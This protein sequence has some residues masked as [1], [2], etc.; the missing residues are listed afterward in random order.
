MDQIQVVFKRGTPERKA[1]LVMEAL[2]TRVARHR[3]LSGASMNYCFAE[4]RAL[5]DVV[6]MVSTSSV[7]EDIL[8][9][10]EQ[11]LQSWRNDHY[12]SMTIEVR[13]P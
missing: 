3:E 11:A 6:V 9:K 2:K 7:G 1:R 4:S 13:R 10:L 12:T 5:K 8:E